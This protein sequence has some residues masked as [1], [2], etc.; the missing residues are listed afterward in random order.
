MRQKRVVFEAFQGKRLGE[1]WTMLAL[2][3][4]QEAEEVD[5]E[6]SLCS[7]GKFITRHSIESRSRN[8]SGI[9]RNT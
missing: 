4:E 9:A 5:P 3:E 2:R 7:A 8:A 6:H 1:S